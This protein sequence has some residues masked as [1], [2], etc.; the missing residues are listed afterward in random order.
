M[1]AGAVV[2]DSSSSQSMFSW[3]GFSS[4]LQNARGARSDPS[5]VSGCPK[6][7]LLN[8]NSHAEGIASGHSDIVWE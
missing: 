5:R 1:G 6:F 4:L 3:G 8:L 2:V 7:A